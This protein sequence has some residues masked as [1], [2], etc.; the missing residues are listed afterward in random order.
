MDD[1]KRKYEL[2][3][4]RANRLKKTARQSELLLEKKSL[5]LYKAN[6]KLERAQDYLQEEVVQATKELN[7]ANQRL[8]QALEEKSHL[9]A[10]ISHE[11]RTPLNAIVGYSELIESQ[12][13]DGKTK[14]QIQVVSKSAASMMSLLNDI[15]EITQIDVGKIQITNLISNAFKYT[16]KGS[17]DFHCY[18]EFDGDD[19]KHGWLITKVIDTGVGIAANDISTIFDLYEKLPDKQKTSSTFNKRVQ[20][21]DVALHSLGLGLPI[22]KSL[23]ELMSGEISCKSTLGEGS[24]FTFKNKL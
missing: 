15:L 2:A 17:I 14:Q 9:M 3:K 24:E 8:M 22:C 1:F 23:C 4:S 7:V 6:Q 18:F 5:D 19:K 21:D 10:S 16:N 11:I 12:L 20:D 13:D